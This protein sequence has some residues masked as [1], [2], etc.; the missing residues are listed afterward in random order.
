MIDVKDTFQ[1]IWTLIVVCHKKEFSTLNMSQFDYFYVAYLI[2]YEGWLALSQ[3]TGFIWK[4]PAW[5]FFKTS[6]FLNG[7][8][9]KTHPS[10]EWPKS[11]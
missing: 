6:L 3:L 5:R 1:W 11:G 9:K 10:L 7:K 2:I 4:I 8:E